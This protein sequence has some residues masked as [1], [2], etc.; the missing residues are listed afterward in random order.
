[1]GAERSNMDYKEFAD[2]LGLKLE[3][4]HL[5]ELDECFVEGPTEQVLFFRDETSTY[6]TGWYDLGDGIS[7]YCFVE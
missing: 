3:V 4:T 1:M 6:G 7:V 5:Q 2:A